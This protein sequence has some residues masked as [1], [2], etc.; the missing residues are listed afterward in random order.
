MTAGPVTVRGEMKCAGARSFLLSLD[1]FGHA[2]RI[3]SDGTTGW[4]HT[5]EQGYELQPLD[6]L[7]T[8]MRVFNLNAAVRNL[9][10]EFPAAAAA[11]QVEFGGE[12]CHRL[13]LSEK[14]GESLYGMF[15]LATGLFAG[16]Q[17]ETSTPFGMQTVSFRA[18]DWEQTGGIKSFTGLD[19]RQGEET[20]G[21]IAY[22]DFQHNAVPAGTFDLP[23]DVAAL[24]AKPAT[25]AVPAAPTSPASP[26]SSPSQP[27][28]PPPPS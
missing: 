22:S 12:P 9:P 14:R 13:K 1:Q 25:P 23:A 15:S 20:V 18:R 19:I 5:E 10:R 3:G 7:L 26:A 21:T 8:Q 6:E 16:L 17:T 4:E 11:G 28:P 27:A 24:A 2:V